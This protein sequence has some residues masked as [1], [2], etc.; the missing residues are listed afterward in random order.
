MD[1]SDNDGGVARLATVAIYRD[2]VTQGALTMTRGGLLGPILGHCLDDSED[3]DDGC[4][5]IGWNSRKSFYL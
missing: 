2:R 3:G 1:D 4:K 5:T